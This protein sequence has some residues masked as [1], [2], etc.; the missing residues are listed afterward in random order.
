M[1]SVWFGAGAAE[2]FRS[3][4]YFDGAGGARWILQLTAWAAAVPL[5]VA[6]I[7]LAK[8]TL[9]LRRELHGLSQGRPAKEASGPREFVPGQRA[10][11]AAAHD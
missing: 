9:R 5:V 4:V 1:H 2:T 10:L 8:S 6:I 7:E 11:E 3:I